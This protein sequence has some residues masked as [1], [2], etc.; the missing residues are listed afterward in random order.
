MSPERVTCQSVPDGLTASGAGTTAVSQSQRPPGVRCNM[1]SMSAVRSTARRI[2]MTI[3]FT[4][5]MVCWFLVLLFSTSRLSS[6][7]FILQCSITPLSFSVQQDDINSPSIMQQTAAS[8]PDV[9]YHMYHVMLSKIRKKISSKRPGLA[10]PTSCDPRTPRTPVVYR[11]FSNHVPLEPAFIR[12]IP[13][14]YTFHG[15]T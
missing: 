14:T 7:G 1:S 6:K 10:S 5:G 12:I 11:T 13:S 3:A 15:A 8:T 2:I 9:K 4:T